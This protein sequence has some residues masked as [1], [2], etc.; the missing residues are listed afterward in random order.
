[1]AESFYT[2]D[3]LMVSQ[4]SRSI[5]TN[6]IVFQGFATF[7]VFAA[8]MLAK[9]THAPNI[10]FFFSIG[11]S[12]ADV[13]GK[14]GISRIEELTLQNSLKRVRMTEVSFDLAPNLR[15]VQFMRPAQVDGRGNFNNTVIG[16]YERPKV[17]LPGGVGIPD[18]TNFNDKL[19]LYVPRHTPTVLVEKIDFRTGLGYGDP[20]E[21]RS[22]FSVI[23]GGPRLILTELCIFEF[24]DGYAKLTSLHPGVNLDDVKA[25]TGFQFKISSSLQVTKPPTIE[26]LRLIREEI[27]PLGVRRT[28]FL[29][30]PERLAALKRILILEG[31]QSAL[32]EFGV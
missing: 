6:D 12:L 17:R 32:D 7:V 23:K 16:E 1:M 28:E 26:E 11:N 9:L 2:P 3:E 29:T 31:S 15:P 13:V 22:S 18:A 4:I 8:F 21:D 30:G 19:F 10:Y 25:R 20:A 27:D 24:E 14:T 5:R